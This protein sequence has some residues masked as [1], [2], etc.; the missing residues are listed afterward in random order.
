MRLP[1]YDGYRFL[2]PNPLLLPGAVEHSV[3][4]GRSA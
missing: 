4:G 3:C 2:A 1:S